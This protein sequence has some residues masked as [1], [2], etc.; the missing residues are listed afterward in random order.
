MENIDEVI[1]LIKKSKEPAVARV[2]LMKKF[3]L[4]QVQAQSILDLR[5]QRLTGLE[6]DKIIQEYKDIQAL[7]KELKTILVDERLVMKIIDQELQEVRKK[8][9][10]ERRT[11]IQA[12]TED[13]SVEDLIQEEEMVVTVS[14]SGYIKRNPISTYRAQRRGGKG[15]KGMTTRDEDFVEE[16]FVASTHNSVLVFS[17]SG[18]V[19]WLKV[20]QIP[21]VGRTARGQSITNLIHMPADDSI[22]AILPVHEFVE[23]KYIVMATKKGVVKKTDLMAYS[24]PR[25]GGIIAC[26][27]DADDE[28]IACQMTDGD[29]EIFLATKNGQTIRFPE[30]DVRNM[31]RTARGVRG[32][33]LKGKDAVIGMETLSGDASILTVTEKGYGKR[34]RKQEYRTQSRGGSGII[35]LKVAEKNGKVVGVK[36]VTDKDDI[37]L[38]T[39]K[40]LVI[41]SSC[42][43][44]STIGRSTQGVR[45]IRVGQG[46]KLVSVAKLAEGEDEVDG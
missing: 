19:Y 39:D 27:I 36:Q 29:S 38:V 22:A 45:L 35:G 18:K 1:A 6:R 21:Q 12:K 46:E 24:R 28:L 15:K 10:D 23:G 7:I 20:H 33:T 40:G 26:T 4:S 42:K 17:S 2:A 37:M 8:Y 3:K 31:G 16:L 44:I 11:V 34:S 41:R 5:L 43:E 13:L 32:I 9:A 14:H 30:A 25:A